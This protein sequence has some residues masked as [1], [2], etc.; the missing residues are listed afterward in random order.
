MHVVSHLT[1]TGALCYQ[2][3][4]VCAHVCGFATVAYYNCN[5]PVNAER[6]CLNIGQFASNMQVACTTY[7]GEIQVKRWMVQQI[8]TAS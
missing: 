8:A 2:R 1:N 3:G 7:G 5:F 6:R 4:H